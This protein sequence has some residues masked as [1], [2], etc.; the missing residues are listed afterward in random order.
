MTWPKAFLLPNH[1]QQNS[2]SSITSTTLSRTSDSFILGSWTTRFMLLK[3]ECLESDIRNWQAQA[4]KELNNSEILYRQFSSYVPSDT[5]PK[6]KNKKTSIPT[7][8]WKLQWGIPR[9]TT[10]SKNSWHLFQLYILENPT[11]IIELL[12]SLATIA[13]K[14]HMLNWWTNSDHFAPSRNGE[15]CGPP[16]LKLN[17]PERMLKKMRLQKSSKWL[18]SSRI[19]LNPTSNTTNAVPTTKK[20]MRFAVVHQPLQQSEK[21]GPTLATED[22]LVQQG[23]RIQRAR[24][25]SSLTTLKPPQIDRVYSGFG[26]RSTSLEKMTSLG[27]PAHKGVTIY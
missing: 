11:I 15:E 24:R 2:G 13:W 20:Q 14:H 3:G 23:I 1:F 6:E 9:K 5:I 21:W 18:D 17:Q 10:C 4:A 25:R 8:G 7:N 19:M 16:Q 27:L 12:P 26:F 22:W